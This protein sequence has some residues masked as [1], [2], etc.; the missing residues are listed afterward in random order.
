LSKKS[1][2]DKDFNKIFEYYMKISENQSESDEISEKIENYIRELI[3][4]NYFEVKLFFTLV[5]PKFLQFN[6]LRNSIKQRR[7]RARN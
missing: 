1:S 3:P 2:G 5:Y 7:E 4:N 6:L